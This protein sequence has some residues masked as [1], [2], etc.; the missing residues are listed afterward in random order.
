MRLSDFHPFGL[1]K[2]QPTGKWFATDADVKQAV[3][4]DVFI[5][6]RY[7]SLSAME[8]QMLECQLWLSV[9]L[10]CTVC[11]PCATYRLHRIQNK[12]KLYFLEVSCKYN[13]V[14]INKNILG[15]WAH[16]LTELNILE[17]N[18]KLLFVVISL[19]E[20]L[21][22]HYSSNTVSHTLWGS[23]VAVVFKHWIS[24]AVAGTD[25]YV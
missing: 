9:S 2:K 23:S 18:A 20:T 22:P 21:A 25:C 19:K 11:Y 7:R 10:M 5:I 1:H 24:T 4:R 17:C 6:C 3:I 16:C 12:K 13:I 14:R 8:G 15:L